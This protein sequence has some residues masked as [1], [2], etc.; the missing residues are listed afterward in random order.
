[1]KK[2]I[3]KIDFKRG[4]ELLTRLNEQSGND[5]EV[6]AASMPLVLRNDNTLNVDD[7]VDERVVNNV[8]TT[9]NLNPVSKNLG[10]RPKGRKDQ[11]K[12]KKKI[13]QVCKVR[14]CP[15]FNN[16]RYCMNKDADESAEEVEKS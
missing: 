13:C 10:G 4:K 11:K 6:A 2:Q 7:D 15:G 16:R 12:R 8:L 9:P 3:E 5:T 14:T 1:M